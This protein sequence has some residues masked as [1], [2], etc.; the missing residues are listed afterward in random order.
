MRAAYKRGAALTNQGQTA[1]VQYRTRPTPPGPWAVPSRAADIRRER[2]ESTFPQSM[3]ISPDWRKHRNYLPVRKSLKGRRAPIEPIPLSSRQARPASRGKDRPQK[4][5]DANG[6]DQMRNVAILANP[7]TQ[8][9]VQIK[10]LQ[11]HFNL[12]ENGNCHPHRSLSRWRSCFSLRNL[13]RSSNS[14]FHRPKP[15]RFSTVAHPV[16]GG[17]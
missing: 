1:A 2:F 4:R 11:I 17:K 10:P 14:K 15:G 6:Q 12:E 7:R 9:R 3:R 13:L 16:S 8:N 5:G